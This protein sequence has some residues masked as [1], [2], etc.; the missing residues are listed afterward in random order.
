MLPTIRYEKLYKDTQLPTRATEGSAGYDLYAHLKRE[1]VT[2]KRR[3]DKQPRQIP[4]GF[5]GGERAGFPM[6][7]VLRPGDKA[8]IP[9]GFKMALPEGYEAQIR[10]R[11]G[12]SFKRGIDIPNAP[13]T[14]D[15]DY[16]GEVGVIVKNA[17]PWDEV[18]THG[19]R[20]AQMVIQE[21][22]ILQEEVVES[23]EETARLGGFGSSGER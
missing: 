9:L 11:S 21:F 8:I 3:E 13:G 23:L 18:I 22:V 17:S 6:G 4:P 2:V 7:L 5:V 19:E 12:I 14:V 16:R 10:P 20:I 1:I 15:P